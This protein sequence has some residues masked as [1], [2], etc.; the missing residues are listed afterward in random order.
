MTTTFG[1]QGSA[2]HGLA[3]LGTGAGMLS[4]RR[5]LAI[6][7]PGRLEAVDLT[8]ALEEFVVEGPIQDGILLAQ[9][10]HTTAGLLLNEWETGFRKDMA[11]AA[12]A[13]VDPR[14]TY[15]H[16]DMEVRW[17]NLCPDDADFPNGQSHIQHAIFGC[18]S[19]TLTV[20][21]GRLVLG[22][23]QRAC[24]VEFDRPRSRLVTLL[25][26]GTQA[27]PGD[28]GPDCVDRLVGRPACP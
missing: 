27:S 10:L 1:D 24:L 13:L 3:T 6:E 15:Q 9:S 21:G 7:T 17:E 4:A 5:T 28:R 18:P 23:W 14:A 19:L 16:D 20:A 26:L 22:R 12:D 8:P 11:L 25:L 2:D